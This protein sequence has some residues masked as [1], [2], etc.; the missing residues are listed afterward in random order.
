MSVP[1][2]ELRDVQLDPALVQRTAANLDE[3]VKV[4][5]TLLT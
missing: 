2:I 5:A 1:V 4:A 3:L